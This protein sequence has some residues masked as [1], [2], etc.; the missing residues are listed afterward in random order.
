[1]TT[2]LITH[3]DCLLHDTGKEHPERPDRLRAVLHALDEQSHPEL[4]REDAPLAEDEEILLVHD[5]G[6]LDSLRQR[7][8]QSGLVALDPDTWMSPGSMNAALRAAG[9]AVRAVDAVMKNEAG[10]A[11]CAVRPPGHHAE[12]DKAMGFCL[13]SNA[14]IAAKYALHKYG[15]QKVA[16]VD[17]DVHHGNGTQAAFD[18]DARLFYASSHQFP[19]YPGSGSATETGVGNIVNIPLPEGTDSATFRDRISGIMLPALSAFAPELMIISAG[20]DAHCK[21]PLAQINLSGDDYSWI[22]GKLLEIARQSA[23][24]RVVSVLEGGYDLD[25]LADGVTNHVNALIEA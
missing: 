23:K 12:P 1:M 21:D 7:A 25:G 5:A 19:F 11:F 18:K 24:G 3:R 13:L 2:L 17:F 15:L 10:N 16:V 22:T 20:F 9:A 8:P 14:A 4:I 6:Y